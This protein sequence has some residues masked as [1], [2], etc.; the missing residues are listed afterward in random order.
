MKLISY[1]EAA[2]LVQDGWT[3]STS[4]FTGSGHPEGV[5]TTIERRFLDT[6]HPRD[7]TLLYAAGQGDRAIR[8]TG[9]YGHEGMVRRIIG[10][11]WGAAPRLGALAVANK[12]E[13]YNWPQGVMA[14]MFRA[15]AGKKPGVISQIGLHTFVDPRYDGGRLNARTTEELVELIMLRGQECLFYPA[16]PLHCAILRGTSSDPDG[17]ISMEHEVFHNDVLSLA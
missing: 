15:I 14:Q 13:A 12:V 11:H 2:T 7:L 5:S 4:G 8:G 10:G 17:N 9:R 1:A 3:L 16:F 6:G